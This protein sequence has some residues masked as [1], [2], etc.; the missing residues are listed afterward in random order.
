MEQ[1]TTSDI[2]G[3]FEA[4]P[5][6]NA[7]LKNF[8]KREIRRGDPTERLAKSFKV[9]ISSKRADARREFIEK[10]ADTNARFFLAVGK[11]AYGSSVD[12]IS[13]DIISRHAEA[14]NA[15]Y[16]RSDDGVT[17]TDRDGFNRIIQMVRAELEEGLQSHGLPNSGFMLS[18]L[19]HWIFD[20]D[21]LQE[22]LRV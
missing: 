5:N 12:A 4:A 2:V 9:A 8:L 15:T 20:E 11:Y 18:I 17:V 16:D 13:E 21:V 3:A 6:L 1:Y 22:V 14:F 7:A 10:H 19:H